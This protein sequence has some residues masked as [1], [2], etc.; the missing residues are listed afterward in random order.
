MTTAIS[1][2]EL[3]LR[4]LVSFFVGMVLFAQAATICFTAATSGK[5]WL[6]LYPIVEYDMYR[7]PHKEGE[8]VD[9]SWNLE[10]SFADGR[11]MEITR[12][13]LGLEIWDFIGLMQGILNQ[14]LEKQK[15][16]LINL[17]RTRVPDSAN[18]SELHIKSLGLRVSRNGPEKIDAE[19]LLTIP[20]PAQPLAATTPAR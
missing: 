17:V 16:Q 8:R 14:H 18:I 13:M 5:L 10:A 11:K 15:S 2:R 19:T 7:D 12:Q 3:A 4:R 1:G 6:R 9:A 20:F